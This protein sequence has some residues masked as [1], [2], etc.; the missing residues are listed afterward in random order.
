M[1]LYTKNDQ[2]IEAQHSLSV[3]YTP[4]TFPTLLVISN[5]WI[6]IST[7]TSQGS[8]VAKICPGKATSSS[9]L[10]QPFHILQLPPACSATKRYFHLPPHSKDH[11]MAIHTS[12]YEANLNAINVSTPDFHIWQ[13]FSS[14]WTTTNLQKFADILS[15]PVAQFYISI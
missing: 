3:L 15:I 8:T 9:L 7:L 13:H 2:E 10:Q 1:A 12:L 11:A 6:I 14:N 5:L 4:P